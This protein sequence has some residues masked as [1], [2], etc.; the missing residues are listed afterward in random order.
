[1]TSAANVGATTL[2]ISSAG[3]LKVGDIV[4]I[5]TGETQESVKIASVEKPS[6]SAFLIAMGIPADMEIPEGVEI[7]GF[8]GSAGST[9]ITLSNPL[10]D[11]YSEGTMVACTGTGITF[12]DPLTK[13]HKSNS[14]VKAIGKVQLV[15]STNHYSG[16]TGVPEPNTGDPAI[17]YGVNYFD[18]QSEVNPTPVGTRV[19]EIATISKIDLG[20]ITCDNLLTEDHNMK[21]QVEGNTITTWLNGNQ[22]DQRTLT[23]DQLRRNGSIGFVSGSN[24]I[25]RNV[26]VDVPDNSTTK[27]FK[28]DFQRR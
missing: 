27:G 17:E 16:N 11:D 23:G 2:E 6:Y 24:A 19:V 8:S 15:L 28:T 1:M 20:G 13:S 25:I 3:N 22:V 10:S 21:V 14:D 5:G 7:P 9:S 26:K 18:P 4:V 12:A